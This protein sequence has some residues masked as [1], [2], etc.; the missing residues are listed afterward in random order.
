M[1][2]WSRRFSVRIGAAVAAY[3][4]FLGL[5][6]RIRHNAALEP[7]C[8][9]LS[10][11]LEGSGQYRAPD[12][13]A[14]KCK[15]DR[16]AV[17]RSVEEKPSF[18]VVVLG[19]GAIGMFAALDASA[20][21]L[22]VLLCDANDF[23]SGNSSQSPK[24][25]SCGLREVQR[26]LRQRNYRHLQT[27]L[28]SLAESC[29]LERMDPVHVHSAPLL[30]PMTRWTEVLELA[31]CSAAHSL[32]SLLVTP[33]LHP[34]VSPTTITAVYPNIDR[35][36]PLLGGLLASERRVDD[37]R[38]VVALAQ[39]VSNRGGLL[40]NYCHGT[41]IRKSPQDTGPTIQVSL[42][43]KVSAQST[44]IQASSVINCCGPASDVVRSMDSP[45]ERTFDK[46]LGMVLGVAPSS[47]VK[48]AS[49]SQ[50]DVH[51]RTWGLCVPTNEWTNHSFFA[52]P[53]HQHSFIVGA[54]EYPLPQDHVVSTTAG[55]PFTDAKK[56]LDDL[57]TAISSFGL[58]PKFV[59]VMCPVAALLIPAW[60]GA[61]RVT[62][63]GY[64]VECSD[65]GVVHVV[66]GSWATARKAAAEA[67]DAAIDSQKKRGCVG[68]TLG[69]SCR[70]DTI[71]LVG[72]LPRHA[73]EAVAKQYPLELVQ[74]YGS[75]AC[76]VA[77][78]CE[79]N[80]APF[81]SH[82]AVFATYA[83]GGGIR[84]GP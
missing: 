7:Y 28:S 84:Y 5:K 17:W 47:P 21:G 68:P 74:Q 69:S 80:Q 83:R 58:K 81:R 33:T 64:C 8:D 20:R 35:Q 73:M 9:P 75:R 39:T 6:Y 15:C 27:A 49:E 77:K 70:T 43:D 48:A 57:S 30:I 4:V 51:R 59:S 76:A 67:I 34:I 3:G 44:L 16:N 2:R 61:S 45:A 22:R 60:E 13:Q 10:L 1:G 63:I 37:S 36:M 23:G 55:A 46:H 19:G 52:F 38:L 14:T 32:M 65:T 72:W 31:L 25:L 54:S 29:A 50:E 53:F 82:R 42:T 18:D 26:T 78:Y 12:S 41:I 62:N 56:N 66:G 40:L 11:T 71:P 24:I 79:K